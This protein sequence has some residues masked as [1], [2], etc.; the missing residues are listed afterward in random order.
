MDELQAAQSERPPAWPLEIA[1]RQERMEVLL[2]GAAH[3]D[4]IGFAYMKE[5]HLAEPA[6]SSFLETRNDRRFTGLPDDL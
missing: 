3:G 5:R 6:H 2:Y 1:S 4:V